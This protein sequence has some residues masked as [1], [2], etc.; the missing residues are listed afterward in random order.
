MIRQRVITVSLFWLLFSLV[1]PS[2][3]DETPKLEPGFGILSAEPRIDND[4]VRL[5]LVLDLRFS[6]KL[7]EALHNG[8]P[9]TLLV[10]IEAMRERKYFWSESIAHI[11]QRFHV[12]Y[13][14]LT[15]KYHLVNMN[16]GTKFRFPNFES[17]VAVMGNMSNFPFLD[18]SL[19]SDEEASYWGR[20]RVSVDRDSFPVPLR[21]MTYV[22]TDWELSSEWYSWQLQP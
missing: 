11:E 21:L 2:Y 13:N 10:E 7:T 22:T 4:V 17:A 18:S 19:V 8:V 14:V 15:E 12:S 6:D 20:V 1:I 3:A 5:D 9:L 16:S